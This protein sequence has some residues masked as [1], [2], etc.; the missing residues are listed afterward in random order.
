MPNPIRNN[1]RHRHT[2][3]EK[4][5]SHNGQSK[6]K[7]FRSDIIL[8]KEYGFKGRTIGSISLNNRKIDQFGM[9][10]LDRVKMILQRNEHLVDAYPKE[11]RQGIERNDPA[12]FAEALALLSPIL[13]RAMK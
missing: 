3:N 2:N 7:T 8:L 11:V 13:K 1:K 12:R 6:D 4:K 9:R 10:Q 5:G